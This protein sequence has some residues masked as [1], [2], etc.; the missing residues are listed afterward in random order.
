MSRSNPT[1]QTSNPC[2]RWHEWKGGADGG[3]VSYYDRDAKKNIDIGSKFV[4]MPLDELSTVKGWH[5]ASDSGISANEVRDTKAEPLVVK[6]FKGGVLAEG[7]YAQIRDRIQS[8]GGH[9]VSNVYIAYKDG[10]TLK[11]G[12]IQFK[13]AALNA[14]VEFKKA[15]AL[16][17]DI[18]A[19]CASRA[20]AIKIDGFTEGKK[21]KVVFRIPKLSTVEVSQES[22]DA[23]GKM[24]AEI[25]QPYLKDY[26]KKNTVERA[27]AAPQSADD[28][29][30]AEAGEQDKKSDDVPF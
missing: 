4:F 6:A 19:K 25:L 13:G 28:F 9:F 3:V 2:T 22:N 20:I 14:W 8:Q 30:D 27:E 21:G 5:D 12:A 26:F 29:A 17:G 11:L 1:A 15:N 18:G 24:D 10:E 7:F 23:A 16:T